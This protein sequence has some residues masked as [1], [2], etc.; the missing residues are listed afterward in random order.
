MTAQ[1]AGPEGEMADAQDRQNEQETRLWRCWNTR[2]GAVMVLTAY[3]LLACRCPQCG[4]DL[5]RLEHSASYPAA[6]SE[7]E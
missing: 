4:E 1:D 3:P 7:E 5:W 6:P 2:C